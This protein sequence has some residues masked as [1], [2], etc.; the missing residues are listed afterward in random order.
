MVGCAAGATSGRACAA[1]GDGERG[2]G[3]GG[4][5][6]SGG[7]RARGPSWWRPRGAIAGRGGPSRAAG[8]APVHSRAS[9]AAAHAARDSSS[10]VRLPPP[11]RGRPSG[12]DVGERGLPVPPRLFAGRYRVLR[13]LGRGASKEVYL[14]HDERLDRQ[15]ALALLTRGAGAERVRREMQVTGRLGEHPHVVTVHDAGEHD[16]LHLSRPARGRGRLAGGAP[17]R[18]PGGGC[19]RGRHPALG[20]EVADALAH[21]HGHGV[22]HRDVKPAN[23]WLDGAGP[24]VLGDFG[25]R[26]TAGRRRLADPDRAV[27]GTLALPVAGAGPRRPRDPGERPLRPRAQRCTSSPVAGRRSRGETAEALIA[28]HLHALPAPPSAHEPTASP[29]DGAAPAAA[30]QGPGAAPGVRGERSATSSPRWRAATAPPAGSSA[31]GRP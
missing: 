15:V 6:E 17:P 27:V 12:S 22:V 26:S 16:G 8:S 11:R 23:V 30:R 14:A 29:L 13:P 21:A 4:D 5:G 25:S 9:A 24:A 20:A 7:T 3:G 19:R 1:V 10:R 28:Q 2:D 31:V 18:R